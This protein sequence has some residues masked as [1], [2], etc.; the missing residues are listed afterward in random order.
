MNPA[1]NWLSSEDLSSA[2]FTLRKRIEKAVENVGKRTQINV[3][4]PFSS[5]LIASTLK[6]ENKKQLTNI[7]YGVSVVSAIS[8]AIGDFHQ[9]ILS[10]AYGWENHDAGYDL[11]NFDKK[12]IAEVKN[13]HNTM[14]ASNR[15]KVISDLDTAIKQKGTGWKAYLVIIIPKKPERHDRAIGITSGRDIREIDGASF[16]SLVTGQADALQQ[17][18]NSVLSLVNSKEA[19]PLDIQNYCNDVFNCS[20]P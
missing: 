20:I 10:K 7:Q 17:L 1:P 18:F 19:I 14:N 11:E 6:T 15:E 4:D 16:Y 8:S 12:I 3:I 9:S 5:L 2:V 13:K